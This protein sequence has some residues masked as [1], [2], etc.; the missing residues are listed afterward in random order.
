MDAGD[1]RMVNPADRPGIMF[2]EILNAAAGRI[3][4]ET[5]PGNCLFHVVGDV[6]RRMF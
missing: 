3:D 6:L 4:H 5:N 2:A 1:S